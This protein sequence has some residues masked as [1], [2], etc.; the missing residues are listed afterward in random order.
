[1]VKT[2]HTKRNRT[3]IALLLCLFVVS[4]TSLM[5]LSI[6]D[7]ETSQLAALRNTADF[8]RALYLA[9]AAVH[10]A[11]A[12]LEEDFSWRG[13]VTQGSYPGNLTYSASAADGTSGQVVITG[14]GVSG[15]ATRT[16][17]VTVGQGS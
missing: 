6:L 5:V 2:L 17:Q 8:E 16:L 4:L 3:G 1:M 7:T 12:E 15:N 10:H 11:L 14:T 9:G 13:T